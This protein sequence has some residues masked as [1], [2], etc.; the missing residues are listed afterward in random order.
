MICRFQLIFIQEHTNKHVDD[1][2]PCGLYHLSASTRLNMGLIQIHRIVREKFRKH[3][4]GYSFR[5]SQVLGAFLNRFQEGKKLE[6]LESLE[7]TQVVV[8]SVDLVFGLRH[9]P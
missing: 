3:P 2:R 8:Q 7:Q 9:V 6:V 5:H 1:V 4:N